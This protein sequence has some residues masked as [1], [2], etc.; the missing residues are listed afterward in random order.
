MVYFG[1]EMFF[2][3][4]YVFDMVLFYIILNKVLFV[5]F[6]FFGIIRVFFFIYLSFVKFFGCIFLYVLKLVLFCRLVW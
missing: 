5:F 1:F 3:M 4:I 2:L 6:G